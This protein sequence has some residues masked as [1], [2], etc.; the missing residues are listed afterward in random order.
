MRA[1]MVLFMLSIILDFVIVFC[2]K[3]FQ[4][5]KPKRNKKYSFDQDF[6]K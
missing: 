3:Q 2:F 5:E 6:S 4:I 1:S